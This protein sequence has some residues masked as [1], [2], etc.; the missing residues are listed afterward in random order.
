SR[1]LRRKSGPTAGSAGPRHGRCCRPCFR[2]KLGS[3]SRDASCSSPQ[4][5][6]NSS[7][8]FVLR[9]KVKEPNPESRIPNPEARVPPLLP[10]VGGRRGAPPSGFGIQKSGFQVSDRIRQTIRHIPRNGERP[11]LDRLRRPLAEWPASGE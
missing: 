2:R 6:L 8:Y 7:Y 5:G 1:R 9:R 3:K 10:P 11:T 4:R